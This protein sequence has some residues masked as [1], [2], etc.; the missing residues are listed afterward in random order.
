MNTIY[1]NDRKLS[2]DITN[3]DYQFS[4][5]VKLKVEFMDSTFDGYLMTFVGTQSTLL[6]DTFIIEYD[7]NTHVL[8]LPKLL[9]NGGLY[10]QGFGVKDDETKPTSMLQ[11]IV[12]TSLN[13]D[14]M[15]TPDYPNDITVIEQVMDEIFTTKYK[16]TI[17]NISK[18]YDTILQKLNDLNVD[19]TLEHIDITPLPGFV[20]SHN[21]SHRDG[22]RINIHVHF[23]KED[24]S[25]FNAY[26]NYHCANI[27][28]DLRLFDEDK[29]LLCGGVSTV[30]SENY[31]N[32]PSMAIVVKDGEDLS[33]HELRVGLGSF[34]EEIFID[35][36]FFLDAKLLNS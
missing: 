15:N 4:D 14:A 11:F 8:T 28:S 26:Q 36:T 7:S 31:W 24:G 17:D 27:L 33:V 10:I 9:S 19:T 18:Q 3:V 34:C 29:L 6:D 23:K 22:N 30:S 20:M 1:V 2:S 21:V 32:V 35:G 16:P 25:G 5:K 13:I 12:M